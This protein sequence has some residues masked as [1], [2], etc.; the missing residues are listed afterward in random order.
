MNKRTLELL[1]SEGLRVVRQGGW[2]SL[3]FTSNEGAGIAVVLTVGA[4]RALG[5]CLRKA[6][7]GAMP[8]DVRRVQ[9]DS[10]ACKVGCIDGR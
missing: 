8:P 10:I 3:E 2:V 9:A 7:D 1:H 4:A 6:T 5:L